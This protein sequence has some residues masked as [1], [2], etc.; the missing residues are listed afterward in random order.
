MDRRGSRALA[1]LAFGLALVLAASSSGAA[2]PAVAESA[3]CRAGAGQVQFLT[4]IRNTR[5]SN[6]D[7]LGVSVDGHAEITALR[8]EVHDTDADAAER[9]G[10]VH[11][12][13]FAL[14]EIA[15]SRGAVLNGV[16]GH[17]AVIL[18]G[19]IVAGAKTATLVV[20]YLHN[21]L[22][23]EFRE[24][25]VRLARGEDANWH[26]L[27]AASR[28]VPVVLIKTWALPLVGTVGIDTLQ[29]ICTE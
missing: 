6:Y 17:D 18:H 13:E 26:L 28:P 7:C 8:F 3:G 24:C 16:P 14:R 4:T 25:G 1:R 15:S 29:G 20:R 19:E 5:D 21:G 12:R 2:A 11:V 27:D 9:T 22:T 23:G 10:G